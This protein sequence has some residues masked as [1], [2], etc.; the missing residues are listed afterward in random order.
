MSK[1]SELGSI[2]GANTRSE[3]LFVI[4]NLVQG[5]DGT[6]NIT[7][8]EL[9]EAIQYEVFS[10][11]TITGGTISGVVMSD[12]QLENVTIDDS[13]MNDSE[14]VRSTFTAGDIFDST[15]NNLTITQSTFTDGELFSSTG[16]DLD[17]ANSTFTEGAIFDS[18]ANNITITESTFTDGGIFDSTA[19]NIAITESTF[20]D[21]SIFDS[22]ANNITMTNS[23]IANSTFTDGEIFDSTGNNMVITQSE[24]SE[25][26]IFDTVANTMTITDSEFSEGIGSNNVFTDTSLDTGTM[27]D[28]D[29]VNSTANNVVITNSSF[30]EGNI[31]DTVANTMTIT[32]SDF[33]DSTGSNNTFTDTTL[34]DGT[35]NNFVITDS[36]ANN[37]T[38]TSSVFEDG[39][40][41][42]SRIVN[43]KIFDS[44]ANNMT[45][46]QSTFDSGDVT[47]SDLSNFEM[48]LDKI[49]DPSIDENSW[50]ALKNVKTGETEKITYAQVFNEFAKTTS[51][52]LKVHVDASSGNDKNPGSMLAPVQTLEKAFEICLEKAGGVYERDAVNNAVHISV[53]PGTYYTKGELFL[54]DDCSI[55]STGGQYATVIELLPGYENNNGIL[56]GSGC[57]VQGFGYQNFK[58]DN[59]D[60]PESGFAIAYRPGA[61]LRRSPYLR[62]SSQLSNFLRE[63]VE[64]PL[65]PFNSRGTVYDLGREIFIDPGYTG[66]FLEDD[67]VTFSSGATGYISRSSELLSENLIYVRNLKNNIGFKAGDTITAE[68][69][70]VGIVTTIGID[71]FPNREVGRGGGCVLADRRVL[72]PDSLYTYV[73]C[74]GFTPR[75]QNGIGYVARD[76][77]GI[78][79][80]GSL[81]IFT[82]CAFY[83]LNGGQMTLNNSGSQFGDISMRSKG[84][85]EVFVPRSTSNPLLQNK[86]FAADLREKRNEVLDD[87]LEHLTKPVAESGLGYTGYD[88]D[89]CERD[90]GLILTGVGLDLASGSNYW[91]RLAGITYRSP[92]SYVVVNDQLDE[93][94][95]SLRYLQ[96]R[97]EDLFD[98]TDVT[99]NTNANTSFDELFSV[100]EFGEDYASDI[101]F[102][103]T[104]VPTR[105]NSRVLL[106]EN[107]AFIA[108]ELIDWIENNDEF[109]AYDGIKCRRDTEDYILPAVKR[110]L[111]L[112]TN[113]NSITAGFAYYMAT[114]RKVVGGQREE[115]VGAY[116]RL[117]D[118]TTELLDGISYTATSRAEES[119]NSIIDIL[120]G[121]GSTLEVTDAT[122]NPSTGISTFT[123]GPHGLTVGRRILIAPNSIF[124]TCDMDNYQSEHAAPDVHHPFYNKP[125]TITA[126]TAET[127]TMNVGKSAI[128]WAHKFARA[129]SGPITV[130]GSEITYSDNA[131]ID[132]NKLNARKQLQANKVYIQDNLTGWIN[133]NYFVYDQ[134]KCERDVSDYLIPALG[135]DIATQSNF[136]SVYAGI[137]YRGATG[138][139]VINNELAQTTAAIT[140]LGSASGTILTGAGLGAGV[141][142]LNNRIS[143]MTSILNG[144]AIPA[145]TFTDPGAA[146]LTTNQSYARDKLQE[147]KAFIQA[148]VVAWLDDNYFTYDGDKCQRDVGYILDAITRDVLTNSNYH[149]V[150][151]G[152][153]YRS[154][155]PGA[156]NVITNELTQTVASIADIRDKLSALLVGNAQARA[157]AGFNEMIDI[158]SNGTANADPITFG[159]SIGVP[160]T[161]ARTTLQLNKVFLQKEATAFIAKNF[162]DHDYTEASCER[163]VGFLVDAASWDVEHG[164]NTAS[165]D[166]AQIYFQNAVNIGLPANQIE[167]TLATFKHLVSVASDIVRDIPVVATTGN[168]ESQDLTGTDVGILVAS[169]VRSLMSIV[170]DAIEDDRLSTLTRIAP[171]AEA[172]EYALA[173]TI[174]A[175]RTPEL[176]AGVITYLAE[177]YNGHAYN[178]AKCERDT[179]YIVDAISKD[180]EYGSNSNTIDV[181]EYYF[182]RPAGVFDNAIEVLGQFKTLAD[183]GSIDNTDIFGIDPLDINVLPENQRVATGLV[184]SHIADVMQL[185]VQGSTVTPTTGNNVNQVTIGNVATATEGTTVHDLTEIIA[186]RVSLPDLRDLPTLV[187]PIYDANRKVGREMIQANKSFL[188]KEMTAYLDDQYFT[189]D[190]AKCSRDAGLILDAVKRDVL[191]GSNYNSVFAGLSYRIGVPETDKVVE[192]QLVETIGAVKYIQTVANA[193]I[194][195]PTAINR[196]N[197]AFA[198]IIDVMGNGRL[199]ADTINFGTEALSATRLQGR[200]NLQTLKPFVVAETTAWLNDKYYTYDDAKCKRDT[201]FILDAIELDVALGTNF[202]SIQAGLAYY[203]ATAAYT[204]SDQ[205][206]QTIAAFNALG[207]EL[208]T[209]TIADGPSQTRISDAIAEIVD[210][211]DN[212]VGSANALTWTD[213]GVNANETNARIQIQNNKDFAVAEITAWIDQNLPIYDQAKCTRDIGFILD[214]VRRDLAFGGTYN[215]VTIGNTYLMSGAAYLMSEQNIYTVAGVEYA[216]DT[217]LGTPGITSAV[218]ISNLFGNVIDVLAKTITT[219]VTP[220]YPV[221]PGSVYQTAARIN[222]KSAIQ[223][224]RATIL[225]DMISYIGENYPTLQYDEALCERDGGLIL[226]ALSHDIMYGGTVGVTYAATMY[227]SGSVPQLGVGENLAASSAFFYLASLVNTYVTTETEQLRIIDLIDIVVDPI[228]ANSDSVIIA[229]VE[230]DATN[231]DYVEANIISG[232]TATISSGTPAYITANYPIYD[233]AKCER[234]TGYLVDAISHDIQYGGNR[235]IIASAN[236]YFNQDGTNVLQVN[237]QDSTREAYK[238]L[239][240]IL[241]DIATQTVVTP[242][243]GNAVSQVTSGTPATADEQARIETLMNVIIRIVDDESAVN[244]PA[245][246]EPDIT[247]APANF[248]ASN[249]TIAGSRSTLQ[250]YVVNFLAGGYHTEKCQEDLGYIIDAV[251]RD[252]VL[253]TS[254]NTLTAGNAYLRDT[255]DYVNANQ[256]PATIEAITYA[257][258]LVK[259]LGPVSSDAV[260][261]TLFERV[262]DVLDGTVTTIQQGSF[263]DTFGATYQTPDRIAAASAIQTDRTTIIA[264]LT[265]YIQE[266][267]PEIYY[268]SAKCTSDITYVI[269]AVRRDLILGTNH[270]TI[271]AGQAFLRP[272]AANILGVQSTAH[273][274]ALDYARDLLVNLPDVRSSGEITDLFKNITEVIKTNKTYS[275]SLFPTTEGS[276]YQ[277]DLDREQ[278]VANIQGSKNSI[279]SQ[280]TDWIGVNYGSLV[281]DIA[282]CERDVG[283][284]LDALCHDVK[285]G[286]NSSSIYSATAYLV[287]TETQLGTEDE[288]LATVAAYTQLKP[289]IADF[290][291]GLDTSNINKIQTLLDIIID[292]IDAGNLTSLPAVVDIDT[293]GLDSTEY[294][295]IVAGQASIISSTVSWVSTEYPTYDVA[296]CERDAGFILDALTHDIKY[297]GNTASRQCAL[298]YFVDGVLNV[299]SNPAEITASIGAYEHLKTLVNVSVTT[300]PEQTRVTDLLDVTITVLTSQDFAD[301]PATVEINTV[302][303]GV[304]EYDAIVAG[305]ASILTATTDY[306]E[307]T[308][309]NGLGYNAASCERDIGYLIDAVSFDIQHGGNTA[310]R[311]DAILYFMNA[312]SVLPA[313]QKRA[314]YKVFNHIANVLFST[315]QNITVTPTTGNSVSLPSVTGTNSATATVIKTLINVVADVI[316]VDSLAGLPES[317]EPNALTYNIVYQNAVNEINLI[318]SDAARGAIDYLVKEYNGLPYNAAKCERDTGYIVDAVSYDINYG[319][320]WGINQFAKMYF[321]NAVN[322]LPIDQREATKKAFTHLSGV[323]ENVVMGTAV[324]PSTNNDVSQVT[325]G[326]TAWPTIAT[327]AKG[328]VAYIADIADDSNNSAIM[329]TV[330]ANTGWMDATYFAS[331]NTLNAN[332]DTLTTSVT[333]YITAELNGLS[334]N[335]AQ[336]RRDIGFIVDGVSHDIQYGGNAGTLI[337]AQIYFENALSVL[338]RAQR[339]QTADAYEYLG[340]LLREIV[341]GANTQDADYTSTPQDFTQPITSS[342][343]AGRVQSLV[344]II[345]KV[346][347]NDDVD[348]LPILEEPVADWADADV[349]LASEAIESN[350]QELADDMIAWIAQEYT[351]LDYKKAKCKRD[352]GYLLDAFSY[353]INYGG[354]TASRWNADFYFWNNIYRIPEDQRIPTAKSYRQL[355]VICK[356]IIE[357][358]YPDQNMATGL[359]GR[360]EG[361]KVLGL[362]NMFYLTQY[363]NDTKLLDVREEPDFQ[364]FS[365]NAL[366]E[367]K[368]LIY[369]NKAALQQDT[370]RFVGATYGFIDY[371][372]TRR[373]GDNLIEAIINDFRFINTSPGT[374]TEGSQNAVRSYTA[375]FFDWNGRHNF[376]VFNPTTVGLKYKGSYNTIGEI[377]AITDAKPFWAYILAD[378]INTSYYTGDIYYWNGIQFVSDGANNTELLDAFVGCWDKMKDYIIANISPNS[379]V[380]IMLE[381]LIDDC[382]KGS[383]LRPTT[384]TFGSLVESIAH[385]FNGASAGVNR[386]ALPLNFRNLGSA[387]SAIASVLYEEG[388]RIRWSGADELNNQYFARGLRINGRTGRI[389]GRPFTSSVRKLA[390]RASQSRAFV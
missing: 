31:F 186:S 259:A 42:D 247:W 40:I 297:G 132:G 146:G 242:S 128:T 150:F 384:L 59:F 263:P 102:T 308:Y 2:T 226:D 194:T 6:K 269:D 198:E 361:N 3:D 212:G 85:T 312:N 339:V 139:S 94:L 149:S 273:L 177:N 165:I 387:I 206:P 27:T 162:P 332:N 302:G 28:F 216:R 348:V 278:L 67:E 78:N 244:I 155:N 134:D 217:I 156:V 236:I 193:S 170:I 272:S 130:L 380:N 185:I 248:Q 64:P 46:S 69:G 152:K 168:V 176:S 25:G 255:S 154:G 143:D 341:S 47:N 57:Y 210:I 60:Y 129:T 213:P 219:Y 223:S 108:E 184:Y 285:Y 233:V 77:A 9:V 189:F 346:I 144:G 207:T 262:I 167:P 280:L 4:V 44:I 43:N 18:T 241:K 38:I 199:A 326:I 171:S 364:D 35:A 345:E 161:T 160:Y 121:T 294:D 80:I 374:G 135:R 104:G 250:S 366:I 61:K 179:G 72:D 8:E 110:D 96:S 283:Y 187:A 367:A 260:I 45:I 347:R 117:K 65:N 200:E 140:H 68:S 131:A 362:A 32:D 292:V 88:A 246:T 204:I 371:G 268:D 270:N 354:N 164:T 17:I 286:G 74:F 147:N 136:N 314:T 48:E 310:T 53:G 148:E 378:D 205:K 126:V 50:F 97:V 289:I 357:G 1:I 324:T 127:I 296:D 98:E 118:Q 230:P 277:I 336:C 133:Y 13:V 365:T 321:V 369:R 377:N 271:T 81:S 243:T 240:S 254:H 322:V 287:G 30:S 329:P 23:E 245:K 26:I 116:G 234:D 106:Q 238:H 141:T 11:I 209:N 319:G 356:S 383:I 157:T 188:Q 353:D 109:F 239:K 295:A 315:V 338:P 370:V 251:R 86:D 125:Y 299:Y 119:F 54:P 343:E 122:Y 265:A 29:I 227:F 208:T 375:A 224:N 381:G 173:A 191:T 95:T 82:R 12:S 178:Q 304:S 373:D 215:T 276:T 21:G 33:S 19:N 363:F 36:T 151:A 328:L 16:D 181:A 264:D 175:S 349:I 305:T 73:L 301:I 137:A 388:G 360:T 327:E 342:S 58:V 291:T 358:S 182:V 169:K 368:E 51:Q 307:T 66:E 107:K 359:G 228:I 232:E 318:K 316:K 288:R 76:G 91:S 100:L 101:I 355:G 39:D 10:R 190:G 84:S 221:T 83:A 174:I 90:A 49:F 5:D 79:G 71:D 293:T 196:S 41:I 14:I 75:T 114:A 340:V 55:T 22:T 222:A 252:L 267:Y 113:Y 87:M 303:L 274:A 333:D 258:D 92:I 158:L 214:A 211:I 192:D 103:D 256:T 172:P 7:R 99:I 320:T 331:Y 351:V 386:N 24:F 203:N 290:T 201:G 225:T 379:D 37:A 237:E 313:Y 93:T 376:P 89:K 309:P 63:D 249:A 153:A 279:A 34:L 105:T 183:G 231:I 284:I 306:I 123:V 330:D 120:A 56:V 261:D 197:S 281:Y 112:D 218:E 300:G 20:T 257:R 385:Q 382:L 166:V 138:A 323:I 111:L 195:D 335:E 163:D 282:K 311:N 70:G 124:F 275:T 352:V 62:D 253:G 202:N 337:N 145:V 317:E 325:T 334:Y 390:R 180:V 229:A 115:T 350:K 15:A 298:S 372:L 389:E 235:A 344:K 142:P 52:A 159:T 220:T 266:T